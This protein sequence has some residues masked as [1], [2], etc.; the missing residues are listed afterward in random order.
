MT[1][2]EDKIDE[3]KNAA[4]QNVSRQEEDLFAGGYETYEEK[5]YYGNPN[6]SDSKILPTENFN[7]VIKPN[8]E[9]NKI[10]ITRTKRNFEQPIINL[11]Q[12][13]NSNE[14]ST[15]GNNEVKGVKSANDYPL[16][17][18]PYIEMGFQTANNFVSKTF[19]V[20]KKEY[21][22]NYTQVENG[23]SDILDKFKAKRDKYLS[24]PNL[25]ISIENFLNKVRP[26]VEQSLQ[27]NETINIFMND[28]DLDK[29][30]RIQT[31][32]EKKNKNQQEIRTFRDNSAGNKNKKEKGV[33]WIRSIK[34]TDAYIAHSLMRNFTF[35]ERIKVNGIPY[36]SQILFWNIKDVEQNSPIFA[37]E[38]QSEVSCFEFN[39]KNCDN[40]AC[41]LSSGQI[42]FIKFKDIL[43]ILRTYSNTD[44]NTTAKKMNIK[45][46]YIYNISSLH[47]SHKGRVTALKWF[48]PGYSINKKNQIV[49]AD[50]V[51]EVCTLASLGE[52]GQVIV[53]DYKGLELGEGKSIENDVNSYIKTIHVEVNKVDGKII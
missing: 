16:L 35:D 17:E 13:K 4:I 30:T 21:K 24:D 40:F 20:A 48:P 50:D 39:P 22:N 41:A 15:A 44:Y 31:D 11:F 32:G 52:D 10:L 3:I 6:Y 2:E 42:M 37:V 43:G 26:R 8:R 49:F 45:D 5:E 25:L 27:S 18:R 1:L 46:F 51:K 53:W 23:L 28:F 9:L 38:T 47:E 12:D 34:E 7:S 36:Q 29:V 14:E 19:Q 33:H